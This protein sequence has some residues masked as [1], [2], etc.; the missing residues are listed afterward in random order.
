MAPDYAGKRF[1]TKFM[2]HS[3]K[4]YSTTVGA[5]WNL[6]SLTD[7]VCNVFIK[8]PHIG[9]KQMIQIPR[10]PVQKTNMIAVIMGREGRVLVKIEN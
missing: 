9:K 3:S 8:I 1:T 4:Q 10:C 7:L 6:C 5:R 2:R